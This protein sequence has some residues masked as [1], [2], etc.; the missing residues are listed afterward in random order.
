MP[1]RRERISPLVGDVAGCIADAGPDSWGRVIL[2]HR[3]GQAANDT[4]DLSQLTYLLESG[5]DRIG[6]LDFQQSPSRYVARAKGEATL[7][8]LSELARFAPRKVEDGERFLNALDEALLHGSSIGG[9][10]PRHCSAMA[11]GG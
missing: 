6:A 4:A 9:R 3:V 2:N 5:S 1:L 11:A 7:A 10:A 8:E